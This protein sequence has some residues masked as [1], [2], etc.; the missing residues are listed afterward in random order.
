MDSLDGQGVRIGLGH[1]VH[2]MFAGVQREVNVAVYE[3]GEYVLPAS[4]DDRVVGTRRLGTF[5]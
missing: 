2:G 1:V 3:A 4:I 5:G